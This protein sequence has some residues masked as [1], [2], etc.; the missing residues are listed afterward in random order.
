MCAFTLVAS[1]RGVHTQACLADARQQLEGAV[2]N[3]ALPPWPPA[4]VGAW[5]PAGLLL[6]RR[7]GRGCRLLASVAAFE[8]VLARP[9]LQE[10]A[11]QRIL[12]RQVRA[13]RS[14]AGP[15]FCQPAICVDRTAWCW[16]QPCCAV[17]TERLCVSACIG[18][19]GLCCKRA[20]VAV[21]LC[22]SVGATWITWR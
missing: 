9:L 15:G 20:A 3:L 18:K 10:L 14:A 4:A 16:M 17:E 22:M 13:P 7:F 1:S 6:A 21:G 8:G 19:C 11:L 12:A 2:D 5:P